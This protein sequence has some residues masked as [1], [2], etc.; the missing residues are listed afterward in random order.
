MAIYHDPETEQAVVTHSMLKTFR[1]CP[2][3]AE[4]KYVRRLKPKSLSKPL[5]R[6]T[7]LHRLL[8]F[9][10][11]G[12]DWRA[13]HQRLTQKFGELFDEER[14][15]LGDLPRECA[16][17]MRSYLWHYKDDPWK[18]LEAEFT[19][20]CEL[21]DGTLFRCKIDLLVE[22]QFGLW[23]VDHKS[24]EKLPSLDY[25]ILDSQ[26]A[27]YVWC[28]LKN[29]LPVQGHIWNYIRTKPP[30]VPEVVYQSSAH[31]RF[32][33]VKYDTDYPTY[34]AALKWARSEFKG[35]TVDEEVRQ[36]LA[37]LKSVQHRPGE[38]QI[39]TF[40][41]RDVLERSPGMLKRVATE[42]YRTARR[43]NE[44]EFIR[45]DGNP[46]QGV[47]R[48]VDRSCTF[49]CSYTDICAMELWGGD[50]RQIVRQKYEVADPLY[51]Y[52]D[53]D[54]SAEREGGD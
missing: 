5:R 7:W 33:K 49:M 51:Y 19:L 24:H 18:V 25:R 8:E 17:I 30:S 31:P 38:A 45:P 22:N 2:K 16:Q 37:Y 23:I 48:V 13:E 50:V 34:V 27:D 10:H 43:M 36:K 3:Q 12:R 29:K 28:A 9:H 6:G 46:S 42:A 32:S 20:E 41:R 39:S 11:T 44:Y 35:F 40:F 14:E 21:P 1:R 53:D 15:R 26:S 4:Y 52:N 54:G 47:E